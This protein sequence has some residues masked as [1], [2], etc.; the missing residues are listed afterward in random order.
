MN[1][2]K[3][4]VDTPESEPYHDIGGLVQQKRTQ[5]A[6]VDIFEFSE[7]NLEREDVEVGRKRRTAFV[8]KTGSMT[9]EEFDTYTEKARESDALE[10]SGQ[11]K[12][13]VAQ[14][15]EIDAPRPLVVHNDRPESVQETDKNRKARVTTDVE[16]Y[17]S[18]PEAYDYPYL[19]TPP[20]FE[21]E[22]EE[23]VFPENEIDRAAGDDDL[24]TF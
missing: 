16:T 11:S 4:K 19:D 8:D 21:A 7:N 23:A 18:D 20:E 13:W 12:H 3:R 1:M 24:F 5:A 9:D 10:F 2:V 15:A 17:A 22:F 6:L 14:P